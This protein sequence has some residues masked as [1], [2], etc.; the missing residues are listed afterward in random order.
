MCRALNLCKK[1]K[2]KHDDSHPLPLCAF[3]LVLVV[4]E[5]GVI[6]VICACGFDLWTFIVPTVPIS[7]TEGDG[8]LDAR[9]IEKGMCQMCQGYREG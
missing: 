3:V 1:H 9:R 4:G 2:R 7:W 5:E 8:I 6:P